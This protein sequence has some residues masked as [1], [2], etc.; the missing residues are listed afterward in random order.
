MHFTMHSFLCH[1]F[2]MLHANCTPYSKLLV[3]VKHG[4]TLG[5]FMC[6]HIPLSY[7]RIKWVLYGGACRRHYDS[8]K[9]L[10]NAGTSSVTGM[11]K[12]P[13][14]LCWSFTSHLCLL[15]MAFLGL[16]KNLVVM[17]IAF[18]LCTCECTVAEA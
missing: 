13:T 12:S 7:T 16:N 11:K 15:V 8:A 10:E 2:F 14:F 5:H 9:F 17:I 1:V 6:F 18:C 4:T 3:C